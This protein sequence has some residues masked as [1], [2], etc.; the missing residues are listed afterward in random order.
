MPPKGSR[1]RANAT[2]CVRKSTATHKELRNYPRKSLKQQLKGLAYDR[3]INM[4]EYPL[5]YACKKILTPEE[6]AGATRGLSKSKIYDPM[7]RN[8]ILKTKEHV[9]IANKRKAR[10]KRMLRRG[11]IG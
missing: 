9:A 7:S 4:D 1:A 6:Y 10:I 8:P 3:R 5:W 2:R 11:V